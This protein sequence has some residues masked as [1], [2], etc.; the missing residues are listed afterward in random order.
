[1]SD[2]IFKSIRI[3]DIQEKKA[4]SCEFKAGLNVITS[5]ENHVGKSSLI[6]SLFYAAGAEVK[7]DEIWGKSSKIVSLTFEK[8]GQESYS[9]HRYNSK[10]IIMDCEGNIILETES[11]GKELAPKLAEI[12]GLTIYLPNKNTK[13]SEL[14]PPVF[15]YLPYYIDQD[16]GWGNEPFTSFQNLD[17]YRKTDRLNSLFYHLGVLSK[18][19]ISIQAEID[20]KNSE[21]IRLTS[22]KNINISLLNKLSKQ[23]KSIEVFDNLEDLEKIQELMKEEITEKIDSLANLNEKIE[24]LEIELANYKKQI[25]IVENY[26]KLIKSSNNIVQVDQNNI[27]F[28]H[29]CPKCGCAFE[30]ENDIYSIVKRNYSQASE[31][32]AVKQINYLIER[33]NKKINVTKTEYVRLSKEIQCKQGD[34]YNE[35]SNYE[36]YLKKIGADET[37][38]DIQGDIGAD[39]V[40]IKNIE[41][42][43]KKLRKN[44]RN[45][46]DKKKVNETYKQQVKN[47]LI[48]L[49]AWSEKY[50]EKIKLTKPLEGQGTLSVKIILADYIALFNTMKI[51]QI[52]TPRFPFIVDSPKTKEPSKQSS[53]DIISSIIKLDSVPQIILA[54]VDY[55]EF[56]EKKSGDYISNTIMLKSEKKLLNK[57]AYENHKKEIENLTALFIEK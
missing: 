4:Y 26:N 51:L 20:K 24:S 36:M 31:D 40:G 10:Y 41:D 44:L 53:K 27:N 49:G 54:T 6:K 16:T 30:E 14:A 29:I 35:N 17:Q 48:K 13:E 43:I 33:A 19:T 39:S 15:T 28:K 34:Y 56:G 21:K 57:T 38:K 18:K 32:F 55:E 11:V 45:A 42:E 25:E 46:T 12:F 47:K 8:I 1:M 50:D 9:I 7:Y 52:P 22:A 2:I 37:I 23:V 5:T 3:A